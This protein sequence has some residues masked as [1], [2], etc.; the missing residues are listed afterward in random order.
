MTEQE[1]VTTHR[2]GAPSEPPAN[3]RATE[4]REIDSGLYV[5]DSGGLWRPPNARGVFGGQIIGQALSAALR[6]V[7]TNKVV[8]SLHAYFVLKGDEKRNIVYKVTNLRDGD[9][10]SVRTVSATQQGV[11]ILVMMA[12]FQIPHDIKR[13]PAI[14][15]Q[16]PMP[17]VP[18]PDELPTMEQYYLGLVEDP[19]C[20]TQWK[21]FLRGRAKQA[22]LLDIRPCYSADYFHRFGPPS[23]DRPKYPEIVSTPKQAL[24][25]KVKQQLPDD[26]TIHCAVLAYAS[27]WGLLSTAKANVAMPDIAVIASLDHAMWF[28]APFRAD[29]WLLYVLQS[30]RATDGRG[31][32][33][34]GIYSMDGVLVVSVAQ[35]G[36]IRM[37]KPRGYIPPPSLLS[38]KL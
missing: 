8:H 19:R 15:H 27:D 14:D 30:P 28:H 13:S 10:F 35:D 29:E 6:T 38:T 23:K 11:V 20:P 34:G 26:P 9:S 18:H 7:P 4:L 22:S 5:G 17:N 3:F 33:M 37:K 12:S 1:E 32:A 36:V 16:Y 2:A 31:L 24:W 21:Q 25:M